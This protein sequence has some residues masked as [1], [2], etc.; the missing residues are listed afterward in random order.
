MKSAFFV[1][2][3]AL[4]ASAQEQWSTVVAP[5]GPKA[6]SFE[7]KL[8][9]SKHAIGQPETG[10]ALVYFVQDFGDMSC[11]GKCG[12]TRIGLDGNWVGANQHNSYF[13]VSVDPGEH[14]VCANMGKTLLAFAQFTAEVGKLY[15]FRTRSFSGKYQN[16][17]DLDPLDGDQA[18]YLIYTYPVSVS[19]PKP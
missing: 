16:V 1:M 4:S 15:Y 12:T 14:H 5:C 19:H 13:S 11:I 10:K 18:K 6:T 8:D 7:V 3:F 17:F 9:E 2:L